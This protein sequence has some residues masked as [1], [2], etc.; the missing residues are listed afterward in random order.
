MTEIP[1]PD[2]PPAERSPRADAERNRRRILDAATRVFAER[3]PAATL[4]DIAREAGVG[5]GTVYRNFADRER[6][7]D[8]LFDDKVEA[9]MRPAID[10][11]TIP[12]PGE[13]F[14]SYLLGML[15][16]HAVDRSLATVL[17]AP[18]RQARFP[19]DAAVKLE[20]ITTSIIDKAIA[21]GE[22][23]PGF[24]RQD[25]VT[26]GIMIGQVA[27]ATRELDPQLWHRYAQV[28]VDGT[29]PQASAEPLPPD[30]APFPAV[31]EALIRAR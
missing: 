30:H 31:P 14:R 19:R 6:L 1:N 11:Q 15:A 2:G 9:F 10:A 29:R 25:T 27:A 12:E 7:L 17:F 8:A 26:F 16:V 18:N 21:A 24:T 22:L 5:V 28:I 4:H 20:G 3:G 13:A 23:R